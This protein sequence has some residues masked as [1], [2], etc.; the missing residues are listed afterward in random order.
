LSLPPK[1]TLVRTEV[2]HQRDRENFVLRNSPDRG[3]WK[4][5]ENP[6]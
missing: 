1:V 4:G 5:T 3:C 6:K 2:E